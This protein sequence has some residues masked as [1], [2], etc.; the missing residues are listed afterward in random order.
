VTKKTIPSPVYA[1]KDE[2]RGA[3]ARASAHSKAL[4]RAVQRAAKKNE[5]YAAANSRTVVVSTVNFVFANSWSD[6][7]V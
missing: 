4:F 5:L 7:R 3:P 2:R 6:L 1:A